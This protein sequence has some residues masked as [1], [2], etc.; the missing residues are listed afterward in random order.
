MTEIGIVAVGGYNEMGRNMTAIIV[1]EDI[2]ILD[3]GLRLDRVQIHEDVEIDKMHSLELIEMGAIPDDTIMKEINGTVRAIVCTHGHLDHVGAIS[4]LAHRYK[5]PIIATPYTTLII[6]QQIESERKF[7]VCNRVIPL[8]A[9][10]TYKV[11]EDIDIEFIR[12]QH[13]IIDC[14]LAA[15]HTPAGAILYACDFKLDRTPTMGEAPDFERLKSLGKEGVIAMIAESTNAGRSGKTPSE[16]IA[17]DMVRDVLFGTEEADVGMIITTFASHIA[18]LKAIIEA[19]EEM[20]R[21]PVLMGRSMERYVTAARDVGY[22]KLPSNVEIYGHRKDVDRAFKRIMQSG[23]NKYLP[24]VTGHQGEPGSILVRVANGDTPYALDPG[25]RVIFSAN[26]I[27]SPM[28]QANRYAL[29]T[30]LKMKGA[31]IYDDVHVSGHAYKEDH[32]ELLRMVNPE[33][34]IPAHGNMDMHGHYIEMAEDAGYVLGDTVH[35]LRN[36]EVLY[37]EE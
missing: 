8:K 19:A 29:E 30:K 9:G 35:L 25:D 11:T 1:G 28:T 6:K 14:V 10:G 22:L 12:V 7:E 36:G 18:R 37:I 27:P 2:I 21:I 26:I 17:K 13:S 15:I 4:K 23:K 3:M 5:A 32:W 24:I 20:G 16:Q 34:V 31:R 33:H